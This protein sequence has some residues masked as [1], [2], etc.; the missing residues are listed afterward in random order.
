MESRRDGISGVLPHRL[1][2]NSRAASN[3]RLPGKPAQRFSAQWLRRLLSHI[4]P[5]AEHS[6]GRHRPWLHHNRGAPVASVGPLTTARESSTLDRR[7]E[8][9]SRSV[10]GRRIGQWMNNHDERRPK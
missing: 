4:H 5:G 8:T 2:M 9:F 10:P 6:G 1:R 3:S 7:G